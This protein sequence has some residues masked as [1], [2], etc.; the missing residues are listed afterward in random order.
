MLLYGSDASV[1]TLISSNVCLAMYA[2]Q[3][4]S[5]SQL[6]LVIVSEWVWYSY[7]QTRLLP[8]D[9]ANLFTSNFQGFLD[10][11]GVFPESLSSSLGFYLCVSARG[12]CLFKTQ[13]IYFVLVEYHRLHKK[14]LSPQED[15]E[16]NF[17]SLS[18]NVSTRRLFLHKKIPKI[19][20]TFLVPPSPQEDSISTR[21]Y[22]K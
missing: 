18:T 22:R 9:T 11:T 5:A 3:F 19:I 20:C 12:L 13:W 17:Y 21:R 7:C 6:D 15:T 4:F 2:Q 14:T 1:I 16:N 8:K 10:T